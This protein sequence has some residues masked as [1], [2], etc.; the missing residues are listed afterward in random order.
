M[1]PTFRPGQIL[2][3]DRWTFG[4]QVPFFNFYL[5]RWHSPTHGELVLFLNPNDGLLVVKRCVG[6]QGDPIKVEN[7]IMHIGATAVHVTPS[8]AAYFASYTSVPKGTI[9][10][11]GDNRPISEDSRAYG[12]IPVRH[13][14]G[15]VMLS[16]PYTGP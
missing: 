2:F 4:A 14:L 13:L 9:F 12:F 10:A 16:V 7:D 3:V 11:L 8:E 15:G 1:E 5:V 6:L